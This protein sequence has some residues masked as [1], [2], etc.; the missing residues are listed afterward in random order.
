MNKVFNPW[1]GRLLINKV[2]RTRKSYDSKYW[3]PKLF[4]VIRY[5]SSK[6]GVAILNLSGKIPEA[7]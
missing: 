1:S 3:C 4:F 6:S 2:Q 5:P 7:L